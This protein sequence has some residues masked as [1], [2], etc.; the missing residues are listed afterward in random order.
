MRLFIMAMLACLYAATCY[1]EMPAQ[2]TP[3]VKVS[4]SVPSVPV[5]VIRGKIKTVTLADAV[6]GTKSGI[7]VIDEKGQVFELLVKSTTTIYDPEFKAAGLAGLAADMNVKV[8]YITTKEG[9]LEAVSV[10]EIK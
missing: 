8:K 1:A 9:V 5:R 4:A 2:K 7:T 10:S 6:K 3:A